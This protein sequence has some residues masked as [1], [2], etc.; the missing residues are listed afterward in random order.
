MNSRERVRTTLSHC[1]PDRIPLDI[2][3]T[4]SSGVTGIAYNR[5]CAQLGVRGPT[6]IY[7]PYQQ[8]ALV[9][10]PVLQK[11]EVDTALLHF[12]PRRWKKSTLPDGTPCDVPMLWNE[13]FLAGGAREVRSAEGR[14]VARMPAG[15][16]YFEAGDPPLA[17]LSAAAQVDPEASCILNFDLPDFSDETWKERAARAEALHD[18][19]RAVVGNL[20][21]HFL[22]AGQ[23]LR[24]YENF[25]CDLMA[26]KSLA[27]AILDALYNAYVQ[28]ADRYVKTLGRH[29]DVI[30]INDDLGTQTGPMISLSLYREM[31]RPYHK[32]FF[33]HLRER[34]DGFLLLHSCGAIADFI[35]DLIDCGVQAI[36]PVQISAAGMDPI[37]LKREFGK[38]IVFWG[39]GCDTQ[40]TLNRG[41]PEQVRQQV[42]RNVSVFGADGGFVFTQVHNIQADV[43]PEN[44]I[45]MVKALREAH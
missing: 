7:D 17:H 37:R 22:A 45:A 6:R 18:T 43:P 32:R 38:D 3:A 30:L 5:L 9:E 39:G 28:R 20:C 36:N 14:V 4:D 16:F 2:G 31:I 29:L 35:P 26:E 42:L 15:G 1:V 34:F 27:S 13:T 25:M 21:C 8:L 40:R 24:G 23:Q 41:T 33:R 10:P 19:G 44:V 11:L 12:E